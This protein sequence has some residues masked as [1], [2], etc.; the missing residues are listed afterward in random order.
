MGIYGSPN[1]WADGDPKVDALIQAGK[2]EVDDQKRRAIYEELQQ[3]LWTKLPQIPLYYSDF[4]VGLS[5]KLHDLSV[6]PN[7]DTYFYPASLSG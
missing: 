6:L 2:T 3:Y 1:P 4:T 5:D 7:Y